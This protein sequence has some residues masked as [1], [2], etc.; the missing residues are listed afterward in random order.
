[1]PQ[2]ITGLPCDKE[3]KAEF[4]RAVIWER[5]IWGG[6][7]SVFLANPTCSPAAALPAD[8]H[9]P[10]RGGERERERGRVGTADE[11][12]L[13]Q[14]MMWHHVQP[15]ALWVRRFMVKNKRISHLLKL[16][17]SPDAEWTMTFRKPYKPGVSSSV[18]GSFQ[19]MQIKYKTLDALKRIFKS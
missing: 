7:Y 18:D 5:H 11:S 15:R 10:E 2:T 13:T 16:C 3:H 1:M 12:G 4:E 19:I 17:F 6:L 9:S 14:R 8:S